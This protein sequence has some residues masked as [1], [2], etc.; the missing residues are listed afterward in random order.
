MGAI[1]N[2]WRKNTRLSVCLKKIGDC[3]RRSGILA[4]AHIESVIS[5]TKKWGASLEQLP[6]SRWLSVVLKKMGDYLRGEGFY[7]R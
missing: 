3:L 2:S 4:F 6:K 5:N 1:L 7:L